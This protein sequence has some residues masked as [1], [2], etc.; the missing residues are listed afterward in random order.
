MHHDF[1]SAAWADNHH[2]VSGGFARLFK[3]LAHAFRRLNAIEYDAPW[4][5]MRP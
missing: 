5:N 2:H 3:S 4:R 1:D